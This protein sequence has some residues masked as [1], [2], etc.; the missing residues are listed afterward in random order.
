[1]ES[2]IEVA[3]SENVRLNAE[4]NG[5]ISITKIDAYAVDVLGM[6]K[7]ENY[8]VECIDLSKGDKVLYSGSVKNAE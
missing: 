4:L 7:I 8:Q 1:M 6:T 5:K 2:E 3:K